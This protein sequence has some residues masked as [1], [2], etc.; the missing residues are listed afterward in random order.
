MRLFF[1]N[2]LMCPEQKCQLN[3]F[4]LKIE[5]I[6]TK[7]KE[8]PYNKN[9]ILKVAKKLHWGGLKKTVEDLG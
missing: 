6:K 7:Y 8:S 4:P 9:K 1:H 5:V 2:L 3:G